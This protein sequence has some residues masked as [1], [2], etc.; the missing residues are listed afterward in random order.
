MKTSALL[1]AIS[2]LSLPSSLY[3][4]IKKLPKGYRDWTHTKSMVIPDKKHGL[5]GFHNVYA[6][7]KALKTLKSNG[8]KYPVGSSFV[9]S[10]YE[11]VEKDGNINQG[12]KIM[13][14]IMI[15][16]KSSKAT[17]Y[18]SYAAFAADGSKKPIN[19][20]KDCH[21]C[22]KSQK[23]KDFVFHSFIE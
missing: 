7:K 12:K 3:G 8:K 20:A 11:V 22:H 4:K 18:W 6:N 2:F 5:Y 23:S 1:L 9:V 13:D 14:A 17:N 21:E 15:K 16:D 10:F 19:P